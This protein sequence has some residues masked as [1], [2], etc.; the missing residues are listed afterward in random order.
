[1]INQREYQKSLDKAYAAGAE[2]G[3]RDAEG[4]QAMLLNPG[5]HFPWKKAMPRGFFLDS[6]SPVRRDLSSEGISEDEF[7]AWGYAVVDAYNLGYKDAYEAIT[8]RSTWNT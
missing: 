5:A 8:P 4:G 6:G 2:E 3:K 7:S 1:M